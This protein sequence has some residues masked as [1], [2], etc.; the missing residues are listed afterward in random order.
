VQEHSS[1]AT[2]HEGIRSCPRGMAATDGVRSQSCQ[3]MWCRA[4][5]GD[6][7]EPLSSGL[8]LTSG[9][10]LHFIFSKIFNHPN[11][12]IRISDLP[13]VQNSPNF[14]GRYFEE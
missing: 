12:E 9:P 5:A 13:N 6:R 14:A 10:R 3:C 1:T 8:R 7:R 4:C 11:F 2:T